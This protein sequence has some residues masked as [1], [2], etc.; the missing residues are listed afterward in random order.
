[1]SKLFHIT[2]PHSIAHV[3]QLIITPKMLN[4]SIYWLWQAEKIQE[5]VRK[6]SAFGW[7]ARGR[8]FESRRPDF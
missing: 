6:G 2:V 7:G 8:G 3:G 4:T 1:M 5:K